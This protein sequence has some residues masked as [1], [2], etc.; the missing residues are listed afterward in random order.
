LCLTTIALPMLLGAGDD[1]GPISAS[2]E[3]I[4]GQ[5]FQGSVSL[6]P[7]GYFLIDRLRNAGLAPV[8]LGDVKQARF[9]NGSTALTEGLML[10]DDSLLLA[11]IDSMDDKTL[12]C[13]PRG[14]ASKTI[15]R[16]RV[17]RLQFGTVT[18]AQWDKVPPGKTGVL[19][20]EGDF[21]EG[22]ITGIKD[23][24]VSVESVLFGPAHFSTATR[25]RGIILADAHEGVVDWEI[26]T[27]NGSVLM[28]DSAKIDGDHID[29]NDPWLGEFQLGLTDL[30]QIKAGAGRNR[31]L[32]D[33]K[34]ESIDPPGLY[35]FSADTTPEGLALD[36]RGADVAPRTFTK[37]VYVAA[38]C[39]VTWNLAGQFRAFSAVP[40]I[41]MVTLP[42]A[43]VR[44]IVLVDGQE[45]YRSDPMTSIDTLKESQIINLNVTDAKT[46]TLRVEGDRPGDV[47]GGGAFGGAS[48]QK[49]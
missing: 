8:E 6:D 33:L 37:G 21:F 1:N 40:G 45:K 17:A 14:G 10:T 23:K 9:I 30:Q 35:S 36:M 7:R 25:A 16:S 3:T 47:G 2:V 19:L 5:S 27:S 28:A 31:S 20:S 12:T 39:S 49:R 44:L 18:K 41:P 22:T 13:T 34:P 42:G 26:W 15:P 24:S 38:G 4:T 32:S 11:Q 29:V 48:L 43:S 46:L